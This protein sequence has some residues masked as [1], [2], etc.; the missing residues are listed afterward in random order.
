MLLGY[1]ERCLLIIF[2]FIVSTNNI[3][4]FFKT[5]PR[6]PG[7]ILQALQQ[8]EPTIIEQN[9]FLEREEHDKN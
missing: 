4:D 9:V 1:C 7:F 8:Y 2:K 3:F 6:Y 5:F